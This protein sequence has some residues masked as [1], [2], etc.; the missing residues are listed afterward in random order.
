[1]KD[2]RIIKS[3]A[4]QYQAIADIYNEYISLHGST[5][6]EKIHEESDI[7]KW[8]G[9]FNEKECLFSLMKEDQIIGWAVIKRYSERYGYRFAGETSLFITQQYIGKGYGT[10]FKTFIIQRCR[11]LGYHHL[12]AKIF[13]SN[14]VSINYNLKLG[15]EIVGEQKEV[16][17]KKGRWVNVTILQLLLS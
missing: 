2:I 7:A 4:S 12:V 17:Y 13:S 3:T 1:M 14:Q 16:G 5:M 8:I 11:E 15:Y 6:V 10:F 9:G